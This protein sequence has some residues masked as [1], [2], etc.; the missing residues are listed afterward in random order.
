MQKIIFTET[1]NGSFSLKFGAKDFGPKG[2][3]ICTFVLECKEHGL[4]MEFQGNLF[5]IFTRYELNAQY[6]NNSSKE[7][8]L[9]RVYME[10]GSCVVEAGTGALYDLLKEAAAEDLGTFRC[11]KPI[12][13][14]W[15]GHQ[16]SEVA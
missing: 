6:M 9:I 14:Y 13:F 5:D 12:T 15:K 2:M 11:K 16:D 10:K 8:N 3:D 4:W 7:K 1:Q